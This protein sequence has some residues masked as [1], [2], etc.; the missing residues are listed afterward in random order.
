[1]D[2]PALQKRRILTGVF[3]EAPK[4]IPLDLGWRR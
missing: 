1:M 4:D 3:I 2:I